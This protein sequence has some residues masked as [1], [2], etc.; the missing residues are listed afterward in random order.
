MIVMVRYVENYKKV[1]YPEDYNHIR[2]YW[3]LIQ[4]GKEVVSLKIYKTYKKL[5]QDLDNN[6]SE[7]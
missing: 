1:K 7:Y 5:I 3:E 4:S 2:E 6:D